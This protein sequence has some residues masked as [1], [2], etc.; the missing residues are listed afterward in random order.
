MSSRGGPVAKP[1]AST[2]RLVLLALLLAG[3]VPATA[4]G[5]YWSIQNTPTPGGSL[6][7]SDLAA[8]SCVSASA[9][10]AVGSRDNPSLG[11]ATLAERWDGPRWT[12]QA[13]PDPA[14]AGI[15]MLTDVSCVSA[16][17]CL[18]VGNYGNGRFLFGAFV[19]R[20]NGTRWAL[21]SVPNPGPVD[22]N[23]F[24]VSCASD[25]ACVAVGTSWTSAALANDG[26]AAVG[27]YSRPPTSDQEQQHSD[28]GGVR[29]AVDVLC[30]RVSIRCGR[31]YDTVGGAVGRDA[32]VGPTDSEP[33]WRRRNQQPASCPAHVG[34]CVYCRRS[35][36]PSGSGSVVRGTMGRHA[37]VAPVHAEICLS[38]G[39]RRRVMRIRPC[40]RGRHFG[41][42]HAARGTLG[43]GSAGRRRHSPLTDTLSRT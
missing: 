42:H 13:T 6:Y 19:E 20:W 43:R 8:V 12:V 21:Q 2:M 22:T 25:V 7:M 35:V 15:S 29:L 27:P 36:R 24:G 28:G 38:R 10:T 41:Q 17:A 1:A 39:V 3:F 33:F 34:H 5:A 31:R 23:L 30:C 37:L 14:G 4:S 26:T 32:V 18:A 16:A 11:Q 40:V 9:C